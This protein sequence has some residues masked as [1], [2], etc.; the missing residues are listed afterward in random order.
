MAAPTTW[1]IALRAA[2][3]P[4][5]DALKPL[6][7]RKSGNYFNRRVR[8]NLVQVVG[9]QSGQAVSVMH[10]NFTVNLG[11]YI[12]CIA[13]LEGNGASGRYV[14]DAHCEIR[15]RL[16]DVA[17]LGKSK[18]WP[19]DG[20]SSSTGRMIAEALVDSGVRFLDRYDGFD[21]VLER[22]DADGELPLHNAARS[23]LA[24]AII[25]WS[26][27]ELD[28]SRE[29]FLLAQTMPSHNAS[30]AAYVSNMRARCGL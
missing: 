30:F 25:Q 10:G 6:G 18:W 9:F 19:L 23:T 13:E 5:A 22:F 15:S 14:T 2:Q 3:M 27:G 29:L 26:R 8:D 24:A 1:Q 7:F 12:P 17:N 16:S 11:I 21:A 28:R 20:S 4:V